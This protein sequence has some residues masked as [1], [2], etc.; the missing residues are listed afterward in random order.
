MKEADALTEWGF[1][2]RVVASEHIP[3]TV[4]WDAELMH[5]RKWKL[6]AV[7]WDSAALK[8]RRTYLVSGLKQRVFQLL[9]GA[10]FYDHGLAE[11]AYCRLYGE[12]LELACEQRAELYIAHNPQALPVAAAAARQYSTRFAFDAEDFHRGE[13]TRD[14]QNSTAFRLLNYLEQKYL[15]ACAYVS[16]PS[17]QISDQLARHYGI[18]MPL[19]IHNCFPLADRF[20]LDGKTLDRQGKHLSL[21][22]YSQ[23]IGLD[24]GIQDVIRAASLINRPVQIHLRGDISDTVRDNLLTLAREYSVADRIFFHRIVRPAELLS[25]AVEHDVGL[26]LEPPHTENKELTVSNKLFTYLLAGLAIAATDTDGQ[27][28]ILESLNGAGFLYRSGDY[29]SLA[30]QL[31]RMVENPEVLSR[32]KEAALRAAKGRWNWEIEG[33]RLVE[34]IAADILQKKQVAC[35]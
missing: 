25:R 35:D 31:Q 7:R 22:W 30:G 32:H 11:R 8:A 5:G 3:W 15:P 34:F 13:F 24:R 2:V 20:K 19:T 18:E 1:D 6:Q 12:Q 16:S 10:G 14:S 26:A 29:S 27:R 17:N 4:H 33:A 23:I 21:Y 9:A 28:C